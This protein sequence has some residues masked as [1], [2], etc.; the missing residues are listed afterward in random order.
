MQA[1]RQKS[2]LAY[3]TSV[4]HPPRRVASTVTWDGKEPAGQPPPPVPAAEEPVGGTWVRGE[5]VRPAGP[6]SPCPA[7]GADGGVGALGLPAAFTNPPRTLRS[8]ESCRFGSSPACPGEEPRCR[9]HVPLP[10]YLASGW[11]D[12][13]VLMRLLPGGRRGTAVPA[14]VQTSMGGQAGSVRRPCGPGLSTAPAT[15]QP[16]PPGQP[17]HP[18]QLPAALP[19][20]AGPRKNHPCTPETSPPAAWRAPAL[21]HLGKCFNFA[22]RRRKWAIT[23]VQGALGRACER[24]CPTSPDAWEAED[25]RELPL[26]KC[27]PAP[28]VHH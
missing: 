9:S 14:A 17:R 13:S 3:S 27:H 25:G 16:N 4:T 10:R 24:S 5:Q 6:G 12:V 8:H 19:S 2:P 22:A 11:H 28:T 7:K 20:H 21:G 26:P 1:R 23:A 18:P 15:G